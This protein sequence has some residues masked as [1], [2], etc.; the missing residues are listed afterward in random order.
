MTTHMKA[1]TR[2]S[3]GLTDLIEWIGMVSAFLVLMWKALR[4]PFG[5]G[6]LRCAH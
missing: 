3:R 6:L 4:R 5:C 1:R 2:P